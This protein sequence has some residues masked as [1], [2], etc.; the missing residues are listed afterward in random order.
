MCAQ[1]ASV[2]EPGA[3]VIIVSDGYIYENQAVPPDEVIAEYHNYLRVLLHDFYHVSFQDGLS[4]EEGMD[5]PEKLR[6]VVQKES[7]VLTCEDT[8]TAQDMSCFVREDCSC[9]GVTNEAVPEIVADLQRKTKKYGQLL[10]RYFPESECIRLSVHPHVDVS[11]KL[12]INLIYGHR[13]T[14]WHNAVVLVLRKRIGL[15]VALTN[16]IDDKQHEHA[17]FQGL[18][19]LVAKPQVQSETF[20]HYQQVMDR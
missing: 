11:K 3:Q 13:G 1:I 10:K 12:G 7:V 6:F 2:Y 20:K 19:F 17:A 4:L 15:V 8:E 18:A 14:P 5:T 9:L 16:K